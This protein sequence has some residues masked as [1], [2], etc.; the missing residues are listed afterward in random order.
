MQKLQHLIPRPLAHIVSQD[1]AVVATER[2]VGWN[3]EGWIACGNNPS[4]HRG[5]GQLHTV[6]GCI[7]ADQCINELISKLFSTKLGSL[8]A[9][10]ADNARKSGEN[11]LTVA[12][13]NEGFACVVAIGAVYLHDVGALLMMSGVH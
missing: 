8:S 11:I 13:G 2:L 9:V 10:V 12:S 1:F 3:S 6:F 7:E 5:D 4:T